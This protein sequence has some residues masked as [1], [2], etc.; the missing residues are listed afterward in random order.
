MPRG[1]R[2]I[3]VVGA[4]IVGLGTL[5]GQASPPTQ[6]DIHLDYDSV[7][8]GQISETV[9][10]ETWRFDGQAGD[11]ILIDMRAASSSLDTSLTLIGPAGG[12]LISDDDSGPGFNAR[13]GPFE[14]P[15]QGEYTI[16]AGHYSGQGA[17]TLELRNLR[18]IPTLVSD[19]PLVGVVDALKPNEFFALDLPVEGD[20]G[21]LW[22]L[23]ITSEHPLF[24]STI[25]LY[26]PDGFAL[27]SEGQADSS[28]LDPV[29]PLPGATTI[30]AVTWDASGS[31]GA[32]EITLRESTLE[33]LTDDASQSGTLDIDTPNHIHYFRGTAGQ[34]VRVTVRTLD[35][36]APALEIRSVDYNA[37]LF[38]NEGGQTRELRIAVAIPATAIYMITVRDGSL[39]GYS[40]EYTLEFEIIE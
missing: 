4:L 11:L 13:I 20:N 30:I 9:S 12:Q 25:T 5:T 10:E 29:V 17:Y 27:S 2:L 35:A 8:Q 24:G 26:G 23:D 40:G 22:R 32:Y 33:L 3:L 1:K 31:G 7:V 36:I 19:K 16:L 14:L 15:L 37:Y 39:A 6:Q 28:F 21:T 38:F 18:T 34:T